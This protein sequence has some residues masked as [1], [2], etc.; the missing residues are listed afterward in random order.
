MS[1][2]NCWQYYIGRKHERKSIKKQLL[3]LINQSDDISD[4]I[5]H[6]KRL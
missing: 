4:L 1:N 2:I 5:K 3:E 6:I